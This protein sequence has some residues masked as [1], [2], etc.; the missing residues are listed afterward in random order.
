MFTTRDAINA[1]YLLTYLL[2]YVSKQTGKNITP[3]GPISKQ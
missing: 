3:S 2:T 1:T